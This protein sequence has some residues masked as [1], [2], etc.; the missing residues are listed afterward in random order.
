MD[1]LFGA[2]LGEQMRQRKLL[3]TEL[4]A[5]EVR[6]NPELPG[7]E[8]GCW[9]GV[10]HYVLQLCCINIEI[11]IV[12]TLTYHHPLTGGNA[13]LDTRGGQHGRGGAGRDHAAIQLP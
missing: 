11:Y 10:G 12:V 8:A 6:E 9:P 4:R 1:S 5:K 13:I 3:D 2:S 7:V